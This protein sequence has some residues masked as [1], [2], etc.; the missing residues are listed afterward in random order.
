MKNFII[1]SLDKFDQYVLKHQFHSFCKLL[2]YLAIDKK[3][4]KD[5]CKCAYCIECETEHY[6]EE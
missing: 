4:W 6:I 5:D 3:W 2:S 1:H